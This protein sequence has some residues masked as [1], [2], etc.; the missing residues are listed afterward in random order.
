MPKSVRVQNRDR[1]L[2]SG[3]YEAKKLALDLFETGLNSAR[4]GKSIRDRVEIRNNKLTT[5]KGEYDLEEIERIIV[6]GGGK[7]TLEMARS[8]EKVLGSRISS[9]LVVVKSKK[10]STNSRELMY[11]KASTPYPIRAAWRRPGSC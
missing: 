4:P 1:L 6:L 9:G 5:R 3:P 7:A 8:L 2:N 11:A 10:V